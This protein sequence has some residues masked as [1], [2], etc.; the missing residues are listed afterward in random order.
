M[1]FYERYAECCQHKNIAPVSQAAADCLGC[2][3]ANISAMAKNATMPRGEVIAGAARMLEVSADYLLGLTD[4][5][6]ELKEEKQ[7]PDS[8][9][10]I[11]LL[12][13]ELNEEGKNA[14]LAMVKGL[15]A[16]S[17]YKK[18]PESEAIQEV[19]V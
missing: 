8:V 18:C 1:S 12:L 10:E 5:P 6:R 7:L 2:S 19:T 4:T 3:K 9:R 13:Q 15:A 11:L 14:A 16:Q 17:I